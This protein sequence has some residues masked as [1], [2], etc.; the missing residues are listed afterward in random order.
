LQ[1]LREI[2]LGDTQLHRL[3]RQTI[4]QLAISYESRLNEMLG[5]AKSHLY[6]PIVRTDE[7]IIAEIEKLTAIELQD[8]ANEIFIEKNLSTLIF[9]GK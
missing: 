5:I 4:G 2:K 8:V 1:K 6:R 9:K 3:K 7:E